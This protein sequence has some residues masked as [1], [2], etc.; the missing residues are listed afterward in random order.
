MS[1]IVAAYKR[2]ANIVNRLME[3]L[4]RLELAHPEIGFHGRHRED[5]IIKAWQYGKKY[6]ER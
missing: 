5:N 4:K 2:S 6:G 1:N 3:T